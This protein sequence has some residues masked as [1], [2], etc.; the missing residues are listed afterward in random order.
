MKDLKQQTSL[1][2]LILIVALIGCESSEPDSSGQSNSDRSEKRVA[3]EP[4]KKLPDSRINSGLPESKIKTGDPNGSSNPK[5]ESPPQGKN[6]PPGSAPQDKSPVEQEKP[7]LVTVDQDQMESHGIRKVSGD[8]LII[9]TDVRD[10][11]AIAQFTDVF[12]QAIDFWC[13]YFSID[14]SKT[15]KWQITAFIIENKQAF[16][17]ASR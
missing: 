15:T 12:D 2:P 3:S 13:E 10:S 1:I 6:Q 8:H 5:A 9:Y 17:Q 7:P 4:I 16:A 14:K 11:A